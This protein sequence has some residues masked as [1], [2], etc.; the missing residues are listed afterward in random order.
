MTLTATRKR[1][2]RN[3]QHVQ[4]T[5][6]LLVRCENTVCRVCFENKKLFPDCQ[7]FKS[8]RLEKVIPQ[9]Q[10]IVQYRPPARPPT[11]AAADRPAIP[12]KTTFGEV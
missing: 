10:Q 5:R 8:N 7:G 9:I 6:A 12:Q 3:A 11:A 1:G 4:G 2:S